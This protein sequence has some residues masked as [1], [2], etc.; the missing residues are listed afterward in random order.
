M[1]SLTVPMSVRGRVSEL[2]AEAARLSPLGAWTTDT[3]LERAMDAAHAIR[4][5]AADLDEE[6]YQMRQAIAAQT[7]RKAA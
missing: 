5:L 3:G 6:L 1:I 2:L 4:T 7:A